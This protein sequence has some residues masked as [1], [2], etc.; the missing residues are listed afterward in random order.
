MK[1]KRGEAKAQLTLLLPDDVRPSLKRPLGQLF[2][3]IAAAAEHL[4]KL[5]PTRLIVIGDIVTAGFLVAG[6]SPDVAVVDFVV[7]R[8]PVAEKVRRLI[9]SFDAKV[10]R[11]KNPA[12]TITPGLRRALEK[13]KPPSKI[14]VEGEEDLATI[15]AVLSAPRGSVVAYGQ[16]NEGVVLVEVTES[17]RRE[18]VK[19]LNKFKPALES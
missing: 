15:P 10:V 5:S 19:L 9:D 2:L 3:S 17:K 7:M 16:P 18:F 8:A 13:A 1:S 11:V 6:V 12:G 14:L 4:Q